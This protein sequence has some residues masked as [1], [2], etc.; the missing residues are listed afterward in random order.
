LI[1]SGIVNGGVFDYVSEKKLIEICPSPLNPTYF[2][3]QGKFIKQAIEQSLDVQVC[4]GDGRGPGFRGK[5]VGGLH[6]SGGNVIHDGRRILEFY[7]GERPIEDEKWYSVATSDYLQRGTG[8]ES[9]AHN[10]NETYRAEEI[11]EVIKIYANNPDFVEKASVKRFREQNALVQQT[12][13][14]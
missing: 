12:L 11:R 13:V 4:L 9:L 6:V 8:Y 7:I 5:Y 10:R 1:N 2:E 3:I 14:K